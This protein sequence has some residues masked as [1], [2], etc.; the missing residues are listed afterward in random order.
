ML[1]HII[2]FALSLFMGAVAV[3]TLGQAQ[4]GHDGA[5]MP[6]GPMPASV[7]IVEEKEVTQWKEFS[8]R[9]RAAEDVQVRPRVSGTIEELHFKEGDIVEKGKPLFTI[10]LRPFKAALS[11]AEA[12]LAAAKARQSLTWS[13][14]KRAKSLLAEKALSQREFDEKNNAH[15]EAVASVKSAEAAKTLAALDVEYAEVKAPITGRVGRPDITVGNMVQAGT[16]IL[17]TMQSITPVYADF[18]M[19][20]KTYLG[21]VKAVRGDNRAGEMPVFMALADET[22]FKRE[23]RI[24][25]FD[26]QLQG[27]SGTLRVRAEFDNADGL[28]TPGLFARIRLGTADKIRAVIV[29]D[30]AITTNQT[31][32]MVYTVDDTGK[33]IPRPVTLGDVDGTQRIILSGLAAGEKIVVNGLQRVFPGSVI[34]PVIVSMETLQPVGAPPAGMPAPPADAEAPPAQPQEQPPVSQGEQKPEGH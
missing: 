13:E 24:R 7:A 17:T 15:Q 11:Q 23:G 20:E 25:S 31:M 32:R 22:E 26:N 27:D 21:L 18:D 12:N 34:T 5:G 14:F 9:L 30:A 28:L 29:N 6:Q 8:G 33:V 10:D 2:V 3:S 4:D 16:V 1:K 19:D